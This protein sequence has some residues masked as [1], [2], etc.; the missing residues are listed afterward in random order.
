M[1]AS[2]CT[3]TR[4]SDRTS[5]TL[6]RDLRTAG[7]T[8][9]PRN[10]QVLSTSDCIIPHSAS[11]SHICSALFHDT[12]RSRGLSPTTISA[13]VI[14]LPLPIH[15]SCAVCPRSISL[16]PASVPF[17]GWLPRTEALFYKRLVFCPCESSQARRLDLLRLIPR[18]ERF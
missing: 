14:R 5:S 3:T 8:P 15:L 6:R 10:H 12:R 4:A 18:Q 16:S 2:D 1:R 11:S 9:A 7:T 13:R 17:S